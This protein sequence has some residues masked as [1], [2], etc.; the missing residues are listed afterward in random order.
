MRHQR[1][2]GVIRAG[3]VNERASALRSASHHHEAGFSCR[4]TISDPLF[5]G[6][7]GR[8]QGRKFRGMAGELEED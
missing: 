7:S 3:A 5:L 4:T 2:R 6:Q 1:A 8:N